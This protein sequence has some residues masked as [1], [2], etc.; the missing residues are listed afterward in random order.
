MKQTKCILLFDDRDQ[1][2]VLH[3]IKRSTKNEFDLDYIFIR[4]SSYELK[5]ENSEE[6]DIN[7]LKDCIQERIKFRQIDV[8]LTDFDLECSYLNGLD[9]I[10]LVHEYNP[11]INFFIY[12]GNWNKVIR[13]VIDADYPKTNYEQLVKGI[14][15]LI[16]EKIVNCI[17]RI[18]YKDD[19]I[20]YL[21]Q[22]NA[23]SI[24]QRLIIL[25]RA[26]GHL[27]FKSCF[28]EFKNKTFSEIANIIDNGSD[29]RSD[30]W[31]EAILTQ[32]IAYLTEVNQ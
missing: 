7:K 16:N 18:D 21:K 13:S 8:A 2:I 9:V 1:N 26:N 31:I 12:S 10:H 30:E 32:T 28:P 15:R 11:N 29:A 14:N 3:N 19:L 4:T 23:D 6:V 25:L 27:K 20:K 24:K 5:K 17:D 22:N